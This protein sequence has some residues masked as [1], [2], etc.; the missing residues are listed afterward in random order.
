MIYPGK[1]FVNIFEL[2]GGWRQVETS[3]ANPINLD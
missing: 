2:F 3:L 1:F